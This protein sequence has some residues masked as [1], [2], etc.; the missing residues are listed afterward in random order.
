MGDERRYVFPRLFTV[1]ICF[2]FG[3]FDL[4]PVCEG[5]EHGS[6]YP[7]SI[8]FAK[9]ECAPYQVIRREKEFEIRSYKESLWISTRAVASESYKN[10]VRD[11]F[12]ILFNY[13]NGENRDNVKID[14]MA[15]VLVD[16]LKNSS[17]KVNLYVAQKFQNVPLPQD[18]VKPIKLPQIIIYHGNNSVLNG[19]V[20]VRLGVM[21]G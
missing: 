4:S 17:L 15:P 12:I 9:Q 14:K 2:Y 10:A 1:I 6:H 20:K 13:I 19:A 7:P 5:Q 18:K 16:I 3:V 11:G 8:N 21:L